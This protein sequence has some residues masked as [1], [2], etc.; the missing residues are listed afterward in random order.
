MSGA[1][2]L[3]SSPRSPLSPLFPGGPRSPCHNTDIYTCIIFPA[4]RDAHRTDPSLVIVL[5]LCTDSPEVPERRSFQ[6]FL[7]RRLFQDLP[8]IIST[9]CLITD[10]EKATGNL[11]QHK[12]FIFYM[13]PLLLSIRK[14]RGLPLVQ[15]LPAGPG[16]RKHTHCFNA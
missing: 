12:C 2:S 7:L 15:A 4:R 1:L 9:Q 16:G 11:R 10:H 8:E 5:S 3:T 13:V 14:D 6:A